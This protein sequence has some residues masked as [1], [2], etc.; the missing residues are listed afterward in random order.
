MLIDI[1]VMLRWNYQ[2]HAESNDQRSDLS[3]GI[4]GDKKNKKTVGTA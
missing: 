4:R 2:Q 3:Y 1:D